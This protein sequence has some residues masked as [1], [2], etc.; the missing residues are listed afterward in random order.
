MS[1]AGLVALVLAVAAAAVSGCAKPRLQLPSGPSVPLDNPNQIFDEAFGGCSDLRSLTLEI[2]LSGRAGGR[3]LRARLLAGLAA[4]SS[5]RL[6]AVAPFG[7]PGFILAASDA[8]SVLLLPRDDRVLRDA[9][10]QDILA[11]LAG[12]H[13]GPADLLAFLAGCPGA[14]PVASGARRFSDEWAAVDLDDGGVA[15][16]QHGETWHLAAI[17]RP[18]LRTVFQEWTV[19][20]PGR[21]GLQSPD[22]G[23]P[24][25]FD[26]SLRLSQVERNAEIPPAAFSVEVPPDTEPIT[27]DEL[28]RA[29]P[30][31]DSLADRTS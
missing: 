23:D 1:R 13:V 18:D 5:I 25:A 20:G 11:A 29:G 21:V 9:P 17:V 26:L 8:S 15:Y 4:P 27:L 2:G 6:E 24:A 10:P 3:K 14:A 19:E 31:R 30:M 28:R 16:L 12:V 7:A 22:A